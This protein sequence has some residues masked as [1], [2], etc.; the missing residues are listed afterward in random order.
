M[1]VDFRTKNAVFLAIPE[2]P[3]GTEGSP[4]VGSNAIRVRDQVNFSANF[5]KIETNYIQESISGSPPIV[6]GG[7]VGMA[8][9]THLTGAAAAGSAPDY[10]ALLRGCA[11]QEVITAADV[12][13]T[14]QAGAAGSITLASAG[15]S[16]VNDAYKGM[17]I[18]TTAGTGSGQRRVISG[19]VGSTKVAS[20]YPN[21]TVTTD[22][23]TV[24]AIRKSA[25]YSPITVAQESLTM[26]AY[27]RNS[28]SGGLARR[29]KLIAGM[30]A[31]SIA[32][33]PRGLATIDFKFQGQL[34]GNPSDVS[35]PGVA[36]YAGAEALPY[37]S[38]ASYLGGVAV[39]FND[40]S[41][42]C[43]NQIKNFDDPSALYG[44]DTSEITARNPGGKIVPALSLV[45]SRDSFSDWLSS[46]SKPL[47]LCWG[48][49]G[50]GIS[51]FFPA[52]R[53]TGNEPGDVDGFQT[54][55]IPFDPT[56]A[57]GEVYL[58]VF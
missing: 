2:S 34:P 51:L 32:I 26:Y 45:A 12:T 41:F 10:G 54:E 23:T 22:V 29:R 50:K 1:G 8:I 31:F 36:T 38:A 24:Y 47:W 44:Y 37:L 43:G 52:A 27:Q 13:G 19:Y 17:I 55:G 16:A 39:K 53:Y 11:M 40:F 46:T 5:D 20:I 30:G 57:D 49:P 15:S 21:W 28:A 58:D 9:G 33:K 25:R 14:A 4:S 6:G 48:T 7:M 42:D 35:D 3:S 56:G 18:E